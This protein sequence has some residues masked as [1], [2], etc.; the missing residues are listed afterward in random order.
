MSKTIN[1]YYVRHGETYFNAKN[2]IQGQ[3]DAPLTPNGLSVAKTMAE[4][5]KSIKFDAG[6]SSDLRRA[7][8]T[9]DIIADDN[10]PKY[11][12]KEFREFGFGVYE[13]D[14]GVGFWDMME[15]K[16]NFKVNEI[17]FTEKYKYLYHEVDN[18][19]AEKLDDF[20]TRLLKGFDHI[21]DE[22]KKHDQK[23]ILLVGHGITIHAI[24]ELISKEEFKGMVPNSSVTKIIHE[25]NEFKIEYVGRLD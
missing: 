21:I 17:P 1:I 22:A 11:H 2:M 13:G 9:L 25:N 18:P 7:V 14:S 23:N 3:C 15:N 10:L 4:K 20:K 24:I 6:Y 16:Y 12:L 19:T 5:L 8:T